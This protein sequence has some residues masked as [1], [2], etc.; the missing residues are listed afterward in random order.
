MSR[1]SYTGATASMPVD[2]EAGPAPVSGSF[3]CVGWQ[4]ALEWV[5]DRED[6]VVPEVLLAVCRGCACRP[7]CLVWALEHHEYG[8]WAGTT[9]RDRA[10]MRAAG[11]FRVADAERA[12]QVAGGGAVAGHPAGQ[13]SYRWYRRGGC[14]CVECRRANAAARAG[15]RRAARA[16]G[17]G[18]R[19]EAAGGSR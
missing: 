6:R 5:P 12:Q 13:G 15:E 18:R 10:L 14:R 4:G 7:A 9:S 2:P 8:Y 11:Q 3:Q 16:R 19:E 1:H 17:M